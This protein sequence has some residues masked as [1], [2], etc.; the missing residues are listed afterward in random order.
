MRT[1]TQA[2]S[3]CLNG[4]LGWQPVTW[5]ECIHDS[6]SYSR[7]NP[8]LTKSVRPHILQKKIYVNHI[9]ANLPLSWAWVISPVPQ[10]TPPPLCPAHT[11]SPVPSP[12]LLPT[13]HPHAQPTPPP[14]CPAHTTSPPPTP[15]PSPHHLP[16][17]Q[18]TP[19]PT[20]LPPAQPTPP[21]PTQPFPKGSKLWHLIQV[22]FLQIQHQRVHF[23]VKLLTSNK[24]NVALN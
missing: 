15:E 16:R 17:A 5:Y 18:P 1:Y 23:Q 19:T 2:H 11:T 13:P 4:T 8:D 21:P 22:L 9:L 6:S 3:Q 20:L 7:G 14:L 24:N 10:P 12:H